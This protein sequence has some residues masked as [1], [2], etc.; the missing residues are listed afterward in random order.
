MPDNQPCLYRSKPAA[1]LLLTGE[2]VFEFLQ[3]QVSIDIRPGRDGQAA[4]GLFL[5]RKGKIQADA[6]VLRL[7]SENY[8]LVS[9]FCDG[10]A[11]ADHLDAYI[12]ADD[13]EIDDLSSGATLET[14]ILG[15][16]R[17]ET[18][19]FAIPGDH[20]VTAT[21]DGSVVFFRGRRCKGTAVEVLKLGEDSVNIIPAGLP[22]LD[23]AEMERLRIAAGIP[24][25]PID[26]GADDLPQEGGLEAIAVSFDKGCY[27]GQE[28]MARLHAMGRPQRQLKPFS[29]AV[30]AIP[31]DRS[32]VAG[33]TVIGEIRSSTRAPDGDGTVG[34]AIVK[35]NRL[36]KADPATPITL[37]D[38]SPVTLVRDSAHE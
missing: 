34:L 27:L 37:K 29:T 36:A 16:V 15:D 14:L 8:L 31:E 23:F 2:D 26:L 19:A 20:E 11:L 35:L 5:D 17:A 9:Y 22:E 10:A 1:V 21:P 7:G 24:A 28:V 33:D 12:I 38:G 13:V 25:V 6:F 18:L 30:T 32:L 4:Y 3:S